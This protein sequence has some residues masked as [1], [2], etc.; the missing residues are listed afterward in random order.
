MIHSFFKKAGGLHGIASW[1]GLS[2]AIPGDHCPQ[3]S[4]AE[5]RN[6]LIATP[7]QPTQLRETDTIKYLS[8]FKRLYLCALRD[9]G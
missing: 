9:A 3:K 5:N 8:Y 1:T 2:L 7:L 4:L 6:V